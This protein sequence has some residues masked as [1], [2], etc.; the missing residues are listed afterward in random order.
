MGTL[1]LGNSAWSP[2]PMSRVT[3]PWSPHAGNANVKQR[4]VMCPSL[5]SV[6]VP[7]LSRE[8]TRRCHVLV[9][10]RHDVTLLSPSQVSTAAADESETSP[11][12]AG[13]GRAAIR[14]Y[15]N[16]TARPL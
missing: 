4:R 9:T 13:M 1:C 2:A 3:C 7:S 16:Q 15:A 10:R 5:V 12:C 6:T 11:L 8:V 14:H